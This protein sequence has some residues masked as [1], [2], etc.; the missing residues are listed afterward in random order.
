MATY[1]SQRQILPPPE[2]PLARLR[3]I[4]QGR[5]LPIT[6][7][8]PKIRIP[9][10]SRSHGPSEAAGNSDSDSD[11]DTFWRSAAALDEDEVFVEDRW[12]EGEDGEDGW[13]SDNSDDGVFGDEEDIRHDI[14][15]LNKTRRILMPQKKSE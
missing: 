7:A 15:D 5:P 6:P 1:Y 4:F 2:K 8:L 14:S 9:P 10:R 3:F 12:V 13:M 11:E